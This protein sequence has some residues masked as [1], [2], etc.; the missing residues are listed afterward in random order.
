MPGSFD[1]PRVRQLP[2][3]FPGAVASIRATN[4]P[5]SLSDASIERQESFVALACP[6]VAE[7]I[8]GPAI[9]QA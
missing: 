2:G 6:E 9:K 4:G 7:S 3:K 1:C 8:A 5:C